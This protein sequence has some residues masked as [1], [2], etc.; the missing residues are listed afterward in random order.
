MG[1]R[2]KKN[3]MRDGTFAELMEAAEQAFAYERG[4]REGCRVTQ[5]AVSSHF[6]S[7]SG[8]NLTSSGNRP[9]PSRKHEKATNKA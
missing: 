8:G 5:M 7:M 3:Y 6:R 9:G 1:R 4:E 2:T